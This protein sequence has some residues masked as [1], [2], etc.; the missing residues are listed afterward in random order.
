MPVAEPVTYNRVVRI[1]ESWPEGGVPQAEVTYDCAWAN[2]FSLINELMGYYPSGATG[3]SDYVPPLRYPPSPNMYCMGISSI[4]G[5]GLI[6]SVSTSARAAMR[7]APYNTARITA[8]F[9]VPTLNIDS[10]TDAGQIDP[11]NPILF[12]RQRIR[13][14]AAFVVLPEGKIK[15]STSGEVVSSDVSRPSAQSEITL[16]FPRLPFNPYRIC[17]PYRGM[18]NDRTMF[19]HAPGTLLFDSIDT[20]ESATSGGPDI[21]CTLT[22]LG[23]ESDWNSLV[24]GKGEDELIE[25]ADAPSPPV[26]PFKRAN[27]SAMFR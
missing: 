24:N 3:F 8:L 6:K 18:I 1:T 7:W 26:R 17:R 5:R 23:R 16:E 12:C 20:D 9:K 25:F 2:R 13:S 10:S 14:S 15:F 4:E 11:G 27:L 21:G 19:D 22:F